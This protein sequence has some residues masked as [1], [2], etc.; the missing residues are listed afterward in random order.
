VKGPDKWQ[1][2]PDNKLYVIDLTASPPKQ[3]ATVELGKQPSG[4]RS[5]RPAPW[6]WSPTAPTTR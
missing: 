3:I 5:T 6:R 1:G 4:W 2:A